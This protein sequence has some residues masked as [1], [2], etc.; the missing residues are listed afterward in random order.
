MN[1]LQKCSKGMNVNVM[2]YK[3]KKSLTILGTH[4]TA[5]T[6]TMK[7]IKTFGKKTKQDLENPNVSKGSRT[8][9]TSTLSPTEEPKTS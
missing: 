8:E 4:K 6:V 5:K 3:K 2:F 9:L 1:A 7:T